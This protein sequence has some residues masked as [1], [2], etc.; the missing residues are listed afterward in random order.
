LQIIHICGRC[1]GNAAGMPFADAMT[2]RSKNLRRLGVRVIELFREVGTL[3]IAFS[4]LDAGLEFGR[5]Q[6]GS[7][8][9]AMIFFGAGLGV[10]LVALALEL[11]WDHAE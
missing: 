3:F 5:G 6:N 8:Q 10:F 7:A 9:A 1:P 2:V 4:P 11:A